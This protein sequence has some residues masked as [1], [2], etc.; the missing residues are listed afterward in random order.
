MDQQVLEKQQTQ[1]Q[2]QGQAPR[3]RGATL[4][5]I[6][7]ASLLIIGAVIS[8][9]LRLD[10]KHALAKETAALATPSVAVVHPKPEAPEQALPLPSTLQAFS[11][12]P[13]YAR[14]NG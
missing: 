1:T 10:E 12:S 6:I 2:P 11:E 3:K 9:V 4:L 5:L 7:V 8:F 14:T 13:L